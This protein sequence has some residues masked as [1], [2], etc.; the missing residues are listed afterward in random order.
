MFC[1]TLLVFFVTF[2]FSTSI[3]LADPSPPHWAPTWMA[4]GIGHSLINNATIAVQVFYNWT[5]QMQVINLMREDSYSYTVM[6][7][8]TKVWRLQRSNRTCCLDPNNSGVTPP[9]PGIT[10]NTTILYDIY[11]SLDWL[12]T[13]NDTVYDGVFTVLEHSCH[14][15]TKYIPDMAIFSWLASVATGAPC[16]LAF[17]KVMYADFAYYSENRDLLPKGIFQIPDYCPREVTDPNCDIM[18][19]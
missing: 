8:G 17:P 18:H 1:K 6:H 12:Q 5:Q 13:G 15:W 19:F 3:L 10:Y 4:T 9:R 2:H 11:F 16:R 14:S 7:N